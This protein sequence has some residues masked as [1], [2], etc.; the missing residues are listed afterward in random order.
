VNK[1]VTVAR[2][3]KRL[4]YLYFSL[5]KRRPEGWMSVHSKCCP[6]IAAEVTGLNQYFFAVD[7]VH[8]WTEGQYHVTCRW[9][10]YQQGFCVCHVKMRMMVGSIMC[11]CDLYEADE[12]TVS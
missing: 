4:S 1:V 10:K 3:P 12:R 7:V 5:E 2:I 8:S 9:H 11:Y 6:R